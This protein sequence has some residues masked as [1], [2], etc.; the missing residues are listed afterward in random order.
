[1]LRYKYGK[2]GMLCSYCWAVA[3]ALLLAGAA[4]GGS[5][6]GDVDHSGQVNP[7][8]Y[9]DV[10]R[11]LFDSTWQILD[12][13]RGDVD[14]WKGL[15]VRDLV[16][17]MHQEFCASNSFISMSDCHVDPMP[18]LPTDANTLVYL[19]GDRIQPMQ[20]QVVCTLGVSVGNRFL[21]L[22]LPIR[23]L[24]N[25]VPVNA[26][27]A[28]AFYD[29]LFMPLPSGI[30]SVWCV[31]RQSDLLLAITTNCIPLG[32]PSIDLA[33]ITLWLTPVEHC[34]AIGMEFCQSPWLP[35]DTIRQF[36]VPMLI[37]SGGTYL[38]SLR[39]A[40]S[41]GDSDGDGYID[42]CDNC[43][44]VPNVDQLDNNSDGIGDACCCVGTRG[45]VNLAG[46]VDL[47]DLSALVSYLTGGGYV[48]PCPNEANFNGEGIVDLSD[49][50]TL[51]V[52]LYAEIYGLKKCP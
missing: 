22:N 16:W 20:S 42:Y 26:V 44:T 48:L 17:Y 52:Y 41:F 10:Y 23:F 32:G 12:T 30:A 40:T 45:N 15:T 6:C 33:E 13:A 39:T 49:L 14:V 38:P 11:F 21:G 8:D 3:V 1:M 29:S 24:Q 28:S 47:S 46:I 5:G 4:Y 51:V 2:R 50:S 35:E 19:K 9:Y 43:P 25:G 27:S 18:D 34:S 31:P 36:N 7:S 37:T